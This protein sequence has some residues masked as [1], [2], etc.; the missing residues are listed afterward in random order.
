MLIL[1]HYIKSI[2]QGSRIETTLEILKNEIRKFNKED[3]IEF[4]RD[5]D[6]D[7]EKSMYVML[8]DIHY[9]MTFKNLAG[10]YN[11]DI[12]KKRLNKYANSII[13]KDKS[14]TRTNEKQNDS[15]YQIFFCKDTTWISHNQKKIPILHW[16]SKKNGIHYSQFTVHSS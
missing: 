12:A 1:S 13:E 10:E 14:R 6:S 11:S 15:T 16:K 3:Y 4:D 8:S 2:L 5:F 9:G 7:K